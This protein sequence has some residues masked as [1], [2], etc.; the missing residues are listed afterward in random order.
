MKKKSPVKK[1]KARHSHAPDLPAKTDWRTTDEHE[2][3]RRRQRAVEEDHKIVDEPDGD[4]L[5]GYY[6][7]RSPSGRE[8]R[9]EIRDLSV[10][11]EQ[12]CTCTDFRIAGLG[13]CKHI[14]AVHLHL[15]RPK[16]RK[17]LRVARAG[18]SGLAHIVPDRSADTLRCSVGRSLLTPGLLAL[19]DGDRLADGVSPEEAMERIGA[20][21]SRKIRVS[22]EVAPFLEERA[23]RAER[24]RLCHE[25]EAAVRSGDMPESESLVP[26]YPYQRE[27]MLHLA[28]GERALLADEMGLGKTVQAIT[29]AALLHRLGKA[30]RVLVV[31]PASLKAEWEEQIQKFTALDLRVVYGGATERQRIYSAGADDTA[32]FTITNYEQVL[33]D[34]PHINQLFRPDVVILDEAQRIKNWGT[35]TAQ[36]IK[37]L[38]S[39]Y[40]FVLTGTP[41]ENRIDELYSIVDFLDPTVFGPLFRFN[42]EFYRLDERGRP[43]GFKNLGE[44]HRRIAPIMLRRRKSA[45]ETDLPD[46]TDETRFVPMS[47]AQKVAYGDHEYRLL[48]LTNLAKKRPLR[49]EE[50]DKL[51]R[52][53]AMM[54]MCCDTVHIL[55]EEERDCPKLEE[56][57][58]IVEGAVDS[59]AKVVIFSEWVRMLRLILE[60]ILVPEEI[61]YALHTGS[62]PQKKRREEIRN[63]KTNPDCRVMLSSDAGATGLNLQNASI[64]INCDLPW[65]P[66]KLE[67]RIARVWRKHQERPVSVYNLVSEKTIEERMLGRLANK[68][69]LADGVLDKMGKLDEIQLAG[70]AQSF[71]AKLGDMI[72]QP[73]EP[74]KTP[75][76]SFS[77]A[78]TDPPRT[79]ADEAG[80]LLGENLVRVEER[81]PVE[82]A[83]SLLLVVVRRD[84]LL[85][86]EKLVP[87]FDR[88]F[89]KDKTDPLFPVSFEL[90]D[91]H[92]DEAMARMIESGLMA[93]SS[94]SVRPLTEEAAAEPE[95][96]VL[97]AE[98]KAAA[99][100][101]RNRARRKHKMAG[102]L[103]GG[104]LWE[105]AG[106]ALAEA[107]VA[108]GGALSVERRLGLETV[109]ALDFLR[110][111][112]AGAV[113]DAGRKRI[114]A[115]LGNPADPALVKG[116]IGD[117]DQW[118]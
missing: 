30:R 81:F 12:S 94:R 7:L 29:A 55:D 22:Q 32:F 33:R 105:E 1:K 11:G 21:R 88:F 2:I 92:A 3:A 39:R 72:E 40:A 57:A 80:A 25:Y 26:L 115:F 62:V 107:F 109:E 16:F 93:A 82:G 10:A 19:F 23:R 8:Y 41:I 46:R 84:P 114:E 90:I 85:W 116:L 43:S 5:H 6:R 96:I 117:L 59:G 118:L 73:V 102:L 48:I 74:K 69:A 50:Q 64:V 34:L 18:G 91:R 95:K 51:M 58:A 78:P 68:Q 112:L 61:G 75:P 54:R 49:K 98:E 27:G 38:R 44:M 99:L 9:V 67:Q 101:A 63:F 45:I 77:P 106:E 103:A 35:K 86:K 79:F 20:S 100:E 76:K 13:T 56:I 89:G 66:A 14:E 71:V 65:N 104:E 70:G 17:L 60:E 36:A 111:P 15:G 97:T 4:D 31:A 24:V 83:G 87:L 42:R 52:E 28:F 110:S 113:E 47:R 53:L 37:R 108:W